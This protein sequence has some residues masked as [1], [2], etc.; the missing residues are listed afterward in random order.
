MA[1]LKISATFSIII[2]PPMSNT[3]LVVNRAYGHKH[4]T[5]HVLN[6]KSHKKYNNHIPPKTNNSTS[7]SS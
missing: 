7:I 2:Y 5:S 6:T 3:K 1:H 4:S